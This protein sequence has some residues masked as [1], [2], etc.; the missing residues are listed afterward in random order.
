M[1]LP[2]VQ[3]P[4]TLLTF[5]NQRTSVREIAT[6]AL[7]IRIIHECARHGE[8]VLTTLFQRLSDFIFTAVPER[9]VTTSRSG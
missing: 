5:V 8:R 9:F 7:Q 1:V 6:R 3:S 2:V 4:F